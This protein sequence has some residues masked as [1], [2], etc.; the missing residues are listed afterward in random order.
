MNTTASPRQ[1]AASTP[2]PAPA[3]SCDLE[4]KFDK[5]NL[6]KGSCKNNLKGCIKLQM[7]RL[8][9]KLDI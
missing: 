7:M 9:D 6:G 5:N 4:I 8:Y 2:Q 3:S 1:A